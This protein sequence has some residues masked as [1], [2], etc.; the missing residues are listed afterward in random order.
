MKKEWVISQEAFD[1]MLDWLDAD[2]ER[3]G[4]KYEAIRLRLIKIF[5]CRG[6]QAAEELADETINRVI[7]RIVE[8]ADG[9][10]GDPALYFYGVAQKVFLEDLRK[11]RGPLAHVPMDSA[12]VIL[13]TQAVLVEDI[14]PEYRCLEQCLE[15]LLPEN[16]DLVVRYYQQERQ[17]KIDHRKMLASE[18]GIA[19]NAL[20]LR[21]HRIRL[22]LQRC[23]LECLE[24][25]PAN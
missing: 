24:Q 13:S 18:L 8:I 17:A 6:C 21:A 14:E 4:S 7:A 20:R 11:S 2:R 15:G 25:Q 3:A 1:T 22:T 19:V 10:R 23:V 12:A 9:Y 5:T 16:R